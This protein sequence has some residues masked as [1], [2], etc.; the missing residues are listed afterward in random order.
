[1]NRKNLPRL[2]HRIAHQHR[3][4]AAHAGLLTPA[5]MGTYHPSAPQEMVMP[6]TIVTVTADMHQVAEAVP[7]YAGPRG[8]PVPATAPGQWVQ[9]HAAGRP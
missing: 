3:A 8:A 7:L 4:M 1:V 5:A 6:L 2:R 9:V